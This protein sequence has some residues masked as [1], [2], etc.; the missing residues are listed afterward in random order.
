MLEH[1][2]SCDA[3]N[4]KYAQ[5]YFMSNLYIFRHIYFALARGKDTSDVTVFGICGHSQLHA[6]RRLG[7]RLG[8]NRSDRSWTRH[9]ANRIA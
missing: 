9:F 2:K 8:H 7:P 4:W 5:A 3:L 1:I 6:E